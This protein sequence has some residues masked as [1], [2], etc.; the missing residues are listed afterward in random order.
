MDTHQYYK[1]DQDSAKYTYFDCFSK[2]CN[3]RLR[4]D[5][6]TNVKNVIS[7]HIE[8]KGDM[9]NEIEVLKLDK[10]IL[11]M[12]SDSTHENLTP[13]ALYKDALRHF[14]GHQLPIHHKTCSIKSI[15]NKRYRV[16]KA[17]KSEH[18]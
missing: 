1:K 5:K 2:A 6:K 16:P 13:S 7:E 12:A 18:V 10:L 3:G 8:H 11:K 4:L 14:A 9:K 15:K 17:A